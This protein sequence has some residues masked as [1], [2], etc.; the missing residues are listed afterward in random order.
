MQDDTSRKVEQF[1]LLTETGAGTLMG[2][3]LRKVH[4]GMFQ[5][6]DQ[7]QPWTRKGH[8]WGKR[9]G[10][11][12]ALAHRLGVLGIPHFSH[13]TVPA[14]KRGMRGGESTLWDAVE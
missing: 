1:K 3:L 13:T 2:K 11:A 7:Q 6:L 14:G 10:R 9:I 5:P 12:A 8:G 4:L